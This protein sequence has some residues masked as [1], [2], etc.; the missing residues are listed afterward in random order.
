MEITCDMAMDLAELYVSGA[1]S[2]DSAHAVREHLKTC[3][4]CRRFYD[5]YK[6]SLKNDRQ[7]SARGRLYEEPGEEQLCED[8]AKISQRL[9]K[10]KRLNGILSSAALFVSVAMFTAGMGIAIHGRGRRG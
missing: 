9:R 10:K 5:G 4:E 7:S 8:M 6:R 1:A 2:D 3:R